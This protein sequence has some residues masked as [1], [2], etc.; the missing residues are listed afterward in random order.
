VTSRAALALALLIVSTIIVY[1]GRNG[2]TDTAEPGQPLNLLACAYYA[3]VTLSTTGY[4]D[5]VPVSSAA[6]L[7]NIFV[8]TPIRVVFLILLIGTTIEVL[9]ERTRLN[10][11]IARW[12]RGVSDHT[13]VAGYG[14][15]GRS[16]LQTLLEAGTPAGKLVV[17]DCSPAAM[18]EANRAGLAGVTGDATRR[19]VLA[20]AEI[21]RAARLVIAVGRDDTAVLI[22]LTGRQLCPGLQ[23]VAS[24]R[25]SENEPLLR[26]SGANQ[27]VVS[28][29][30]A[31]RL[32]AL[33]ALDPAVGQVLGEL[34]DRARGLA[35]VERAAAPGEVGL[36]LLQAAAGAVAVLR[37]GHLLAA[38]DPAT[39]PLRDGDSIV[40]VAA[41][42]RGPS[43]R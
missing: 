40:L 23:I 18:A 19:Q 13:V 5:I 6:R 27:V 9:A 2:Y 16:A 7:V 26:Q 4:G 31:G 12:R 37:D 43:R 8:I 38:G 29:D 1:L 24:V 28:S 25:E 33:S 11:R 15:K 20:S 22:A 14:T 21:A 35:L 32:L 34:L 39:D 17:V 42:D 3:T 10:W 41:T 30:A 36:P